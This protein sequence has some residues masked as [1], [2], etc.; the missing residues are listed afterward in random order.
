MQK[1]LF[2]HIGR[3]KVGSSAIQYFMAMNRN[4]LLDKYNILYPYTGMQDMASHQL[5]LVF[6]PK[7]ADSIIV[8]GISPIS[9]YSQLNDE[10][11]KAHAK[12]TVI[13]SENFYFIDPS[14]IPATLLNEYKIK[15]ICYVRRQDDVLISS[16]LQEI[17]DN[18]IP[19]GTC[20]ESYTSNPL[21]MELL[22]YYP[23]LSKWAN[24]FGRENIIV[25]I[26]EKS[27]M[28]ND[29]FKDIIEAIET[30][31]DNSFM[32]PERR[33][34]PSPDLD[35]LEYISMINQFEA[36]KKVLRKLKQPLL[37]ISEILEKSN[38]LH[39]KHVF[40]MEQREAVLERYKISNSLIAKEY[41]HREDGVL[42]HE[43]ISD[44]PYE[45]YEY[46]GISTHRLS[47]ITAGLFLHVTKEN[48]RLRERLV[49]TDNRIRTLE[50]EIDKL[51]KNSPIKTEPKK[52]TF[53]KLLN[54]FKNSKKS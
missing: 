31:W 44:H 54:I 10:V 43:K 46:P 7:L 35:I 15:I 30:P 8:N 45:K 42:F 21:R 19:F 1:E 38:G 26:Y 20:F 16:Y 34:N 50:N 29:I 39:G 12:K 23:I 4:I 9:I 2:I 36:R 18:L 41:L 5:S 47:K 40:T 25:R 13:S 22:D 28:Y 52:N 51:K 11:K 53:G 17:K 32:I 3:P 14:N 37:N 6:L 27:Q 24:V 48:Y 33:V 49:I